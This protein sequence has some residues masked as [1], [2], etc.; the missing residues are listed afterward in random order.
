MNTKTMEVVTS[1]E[2]TDAEKLM[3]MTVEAMRLGLKLDN[4]RHYLMSTPDGN[5]TAADA[6]KAFG[7][8]ANGMN[9]IEP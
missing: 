6:L 8:S 5:I 3:A 7:F 9:E 1:D 4:G 2:K